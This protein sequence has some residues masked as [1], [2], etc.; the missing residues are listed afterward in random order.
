MKKI[1]LCLALAMLLS[2]GV[3]AEEVKTVNAVKSSQKVS[4]DGKT[5]E[6]DAY[7]IEGSN[8][9]KLRDVAVIL[10][11]TE[12][13]FDTGYDEEQKKITLDLKK[14]YS[15]AN[16]GVSK[17]TKKEAKGIV[18]QEHHLVDGN[19]VYLETIL[20]DGNNYA[21]L[22][23]LG[24]IT[25]FAVDYDPAKNEI[26]INTKDIDYVEE[27]ELNN[28]DDKEKLGKI[29]LSAIKDLNST[30]KEE[31]KLDI[32]ET[33]D[34]IK[35]YTNINGKKERF[36]LCDYYCGGRIYSAYGEPDRLDIPDFNVYSNKCIRYIKDLNKKLDESNRDNLKLKLP[37]YN[38]IY[39]VNV[40]EKDKETEINLDYITRQLYGVSDKG[41]KIP[42]GY[43][44]YNIIG[45]YANKLIN[46]NTPDDYTGS[47]SEIGLTIPLG[48]AS[49]Y[50]VDK[51]G[52]K[53]EFNNGLLLNPKLNKDTNLFIIDYTINRIKGK[54]LVYLV[55]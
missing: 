14:A 37:T 49:S 48:K 16:A 5:V 1:L 2:V 12:K 18:I 20:I 32:E 26:L 24:N 39:F 45:A 17:I 7:N 3:K 22:R 27:K 8:Y 53:T 55:K 47:F 46:M 38:Y 52:K 4:V 11:G 42:L 43:H 13:K 54:M 31:Y 36:Y 29:K 21:K 51:T 41:Y 34:G 23:N 9:F 40:N 35:F 28:G 50:I 33:S 15:Q 44:Y 6:I 25:G 10:S 30:L 19:L